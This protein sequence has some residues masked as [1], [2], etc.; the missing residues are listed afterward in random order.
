M[1][2]EI[3]DAR[4]RAIVGD[5]VT[6]ERLGTGYGFTEGPA[7]HPY[8]RHLTFSGIPGNQLWRRSAILAPGRVAQDLRLV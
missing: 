4:F 6:I 7:W 5:D 1:N 2:V 8:E 3:H